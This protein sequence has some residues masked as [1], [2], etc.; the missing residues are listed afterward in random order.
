M[1]HGGYHERTPKC[2]VVVPQQ[3]AALPS[4]VSLWALEGSENCLVKE[5]QGGRLG[6]PG[7]PSALRRAKLGEGLEAGGASCPTD[8][9]PFIGATVKTKPRSLFRY[10]T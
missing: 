8:L 1:P 2:R 5:E 3:W 4:G 6:A 10:L 9:S 7:D